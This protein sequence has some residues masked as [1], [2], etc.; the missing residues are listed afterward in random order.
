MTDELRGGRY[1]TDEALVESVA[2]P[3]KEYAVAVAMR[4]NGKR[5]PLPPSHI[6]PARREGTGWYVPRYAGESGATDATVLPAGAHIGAVPGFALR[7]YQREALMAWWK[8]KAGIIVAPCGA[9]KTAIGLTA[10]LHLDTPALVLVHTGD[11]LRQWK[12]RAEALGIPTTTIAEGLGPQRARLVIATMQTLTCDDCRD[13]HYRLLDIDG[14]LV[15]LC[16]GC[17]RTTR[18]ACPKCSSADLTIEPMVNRA[19]VPGKRARCGCGNS[20][21][22]WFL[23]VKPDRRQPMAYIIRERVKACQVCAVE[24][25]GNDGEVDHIVALVD[26]GCDLIS[27]LQRLCLPCHNKKHAGRFR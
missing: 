6:T 23:T 18:P 8:H 11:L 1:T 14:E 17:G 4:A 20:R 15:M 9:G 24:L 25:L 3:S 10:V 19:G 12:E 27:N 2:I 26:G 13:Y 22:D 21:G 5:V 16:E 7:G